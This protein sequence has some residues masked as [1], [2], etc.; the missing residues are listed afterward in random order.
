[1]GISRNKSVNFKSKMN[2]LYSSNRQKCKI[3][4]TNLKLTRTL[5]K[6]NKKTYTKLVETW[7]NIKRNS[8]LKQRLITSSSTKINQTQQS[9]MKLVTK[10]GKPFRKDLRKSKKRNNREKKNKLFKLK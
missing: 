3:L 6:N 2:R 10:R 9:L 5:E 7:K 4:K 1:M 8:N